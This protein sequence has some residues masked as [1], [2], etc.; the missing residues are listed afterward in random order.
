VAQEAGTLIGEQLQMNMA[1]CAGAAS[2]A[3]PPHPINDEFL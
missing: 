3:P 2:N 1:N